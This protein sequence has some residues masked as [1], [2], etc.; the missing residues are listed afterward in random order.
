MITL[1]TNLGNIKIQLDHEKAPNTA[2]NFVNY[3]KS[4]FYDNTIF[5]RVIDGFMIKV[6]VW[7]RRCVRKDECADPK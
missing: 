3:C 6:V 7:M 5:H 2:Q 4:G 1:H